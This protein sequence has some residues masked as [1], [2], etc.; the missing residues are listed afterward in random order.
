MAAHNML[1]LTGRRLGLVTKCKYIII[2]ATEILKEFCNYVTVVCW[3]Q[4]LTVKGENEK[5]NT[6]LEYFIRVNAL[7]PKKDRHLLE[8]SVSAYKILSAS[9]PTSDLHKNFS[10]S[11]ICV[12]SFSVYQV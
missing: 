3:A 11:K 4:Q 9:T 2:N 8:K 7:Y 12:E 1:F 5:K 10:N 6:N